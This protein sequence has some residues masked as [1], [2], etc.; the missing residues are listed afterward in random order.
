[1]AIEIMYLKGVIYPRRDRYILCFVLG[2]LLSLETAK[3]KI[4]DQINV[5][6]VQY[7]TIVWTVHLKVEVQNIYIGI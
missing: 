2:E 7:S 1:M 6:H 4:W 5:Q 3:V